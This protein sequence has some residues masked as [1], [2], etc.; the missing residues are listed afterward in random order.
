MVNFSIN[1]NGKIEKA[2]IA[3]GVHPD[4]DA[5]ALRVIGLMPIWKPGKQNEKTVDVIYTIPIQFVLDP[6]VKKSV[7]QVAPFSSW[8]T[9]H[10]TKMELDK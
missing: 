2:R 9:G 4:L 6:S 8:Y 7:S 3:H 10:S 5:E 1:K